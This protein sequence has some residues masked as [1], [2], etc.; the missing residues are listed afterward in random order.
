MKKHLRLNVFRKPPDWCVCWSAGWLWRTWV[1]RWAMPD[2]ACWRPCPARPGSKARRHRSTWHEAW[3]GRP[4][5]SRWSTWRRER[6]WGPRFE[7]TAAC[8]GQSGSS[9]SSPSSRGPSV[10][11]R[12]RSGDVK[13]KKKVSVKMCAPQKHMFTVVFL[14]S[15]VFLT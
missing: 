14:Q 4:S 5:T 8:K 7:R 12:K 6:I 15:I 13:W 10:S 9:R 11:D 1:L 3:R 2:P